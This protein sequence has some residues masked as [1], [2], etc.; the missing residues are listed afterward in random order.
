MWRSEFLS[1]TLF[2]YRSTFSS[3]TSAEYKSF[4][5]R[6]AEFM[7]HPDCDTVITEMEKFLKRYIE[8]PRADIRCDKHLEELY[9]S[10]S[11]N[12]SNL[13]FIKCLKSL[14][15]EWQSIVLTHA[16]HARGFCR[17]KHMKEAF[18]EIDTMIP[19]T[20]SVVQTLIQNDYWKEIMQLSI[21][22]AY[23]DEILP[24]V[25]HLRNI[26][27]VVKGS[28][29]IL[30]LVSDKSNLNVDPNRNLI[31]LMHNLKPVPF[32]VLPKIKFPHRLRVF[33]DQHTSISNSNYQPVLEK[34]VQDVTLK[35]DLSWDYGFIWCHSYPFWMWEQGS[36][37]LDI[38]IPANVSFMYTPFYETQLFT[39]IDNTAKHLT[40][41]LPPGQLKITDKKLVPRPNLRSSGEAFEKNNFLHVIF[42]EY[43]P[44]SDTSNEMIK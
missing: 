23:G 1:G 12:P 31:R 2:T 16:Q 37:R 38:K 22:Y 7:G 4:S 34:I 18:D 15:L 39:S 44:L 26:T 43:S 29:A 17:Q 33:S 10:V 42:C 20:L 19:S 21:N 41:M 32:D 24:D 35:E 13:K 28:E 40:L 30:K 8:K 9:E 14:P 11:I 25:S 27:P 36:V 6:M 3:V 5:Q